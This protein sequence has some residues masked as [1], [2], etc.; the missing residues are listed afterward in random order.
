MFLDNVFIK[1]KMVEFFNKHGRYPIHSD[2]TTEN[3]LPTIRTIQRKGID[4][5]SIRRDLGIQEDM[6]TGEHRAKVMLDNFNREV[7]TGRVIRDHLVEMF[8]IEYVHVESAFIDNQRHR[9]DFKVYFDGGVYVIDTFWPKD[10]YSF[11]GCV[12]NKKK[13][14]NGALNVYEDNLKGVLF[15]CLNA[16]LDIEEKKLTD[17]T[18]VMGEVDM[19]KKLKLEKRRKN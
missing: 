19:W 3:N 8:G 2:W 14:Y 18:Y 4:M 9:A 11:A 10:K 6:R 1:E 13:K 16:G 17:K 7:E 5:R 12:A 15:V